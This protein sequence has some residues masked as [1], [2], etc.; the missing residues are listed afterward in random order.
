MRQRTDRLTE[1]E[2]EGLTGDASDREIEDAVI[3]GGPGIRVRLVQRCD[4]VTLGGPALVMRGEPDLTRT[5]RR[6]ADARGLLDE[7]VEQAKQAAAAADRSG[8]SERRIA[9]E[10]G[11]NRNTVRAWLGKPRTTQERATNE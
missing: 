2:V 1:Y 5:G 7:V 6:L 10:L 3:N 8:V 11:V 4:P 9:D